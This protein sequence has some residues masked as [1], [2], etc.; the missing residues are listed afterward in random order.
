VEQFKKR[1]QEQ[2]EQHALATEQ[3]KQAHERELTL[4]RGDL[5]NALKEEKAKHQREIGH[6]L[7]EAQEREDQLERRL[8]MENDRLVCVWMP[9]CSRG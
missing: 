9:R 3:A 1:L 7:A 6:I 2:E 5:R 8:R 4:L